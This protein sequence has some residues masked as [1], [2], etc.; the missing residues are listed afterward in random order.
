MDSDPWVIPIPHNT[1]PLSP[2]SILKNMRKNQRNLIRRAEKEGV[3]I[4]RS[5]D[6]IRD[7][8]LFIELHEETRKRH[9]FTPYTNQ[10]FEAQVRHFAAENG[11]TLYLAKY[12]DEVIAAS[13]H[14][15]LFGET[16]YHHGAS[17]AKH[18]K[19]PASYLLQWTAIQDA[20]KRG[21][22]VY[23][24]WGIAPEG[25]KN[26]PFA[27]VTTFKTGFGGKL[28]PLQHCM[29]VPVKPQYYATRMFE[30]MRKWRRGF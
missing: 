20:L 9:S 26:H 6:S 4:E 8:P 17:T 18:R 2:D 10:F 5:D 28:L 12:K 22:H 13:I 25:T 3:T 29:D 19:I 15:H 7:L 21:D 16:S 24:F 30:V 11:C 1:H 27:G 14:M 23:N